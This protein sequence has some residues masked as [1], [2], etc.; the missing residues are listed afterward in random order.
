MKTSLVRSEFKKALLTSTC[1]SI[2]PLESANVNTTLM[3]VGLIIRENISKKLTPSTCKNHLPT[4]QALYLSK[5]LSTFDLSLIIHLHHITVFSWVSSINFPIPL[6]SKAWNLACM[7]LYHLGTLRA[8]LYL[9]GI[10]K[11][12]TLW[13]VKA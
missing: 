13:S 1:L 6:A 2:H 5:V 4:N 9:L 8:C 3:V 11:I 12:D 10:G 7:A